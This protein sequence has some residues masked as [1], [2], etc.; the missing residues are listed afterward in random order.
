MAIVFVSPKQ[1]QKMFFLGITVLFLLFLLIIGTFIFFSKP[2]PIP[3]EQVFIKP[4]IKINFGILDSEQVKKSLFMERVQKEFTYK[5]VTNKGEPKLGSI[6]ASSIED[7][8][9][10]LE[11]SGLLSIVL[12]EALMGRENPFTPYYGVNSNV[13]KKALIPKENPSTPYYG[14]DSNVLEE[15]SIPQ[16]N[17]STPYYGADSNY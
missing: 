4:N 12:E 3:I 2:K 1:R 13:L 15:A 11:D 7:A 8:K 17:S 10:I 6:F 5:S 14:P 16:D 9:K